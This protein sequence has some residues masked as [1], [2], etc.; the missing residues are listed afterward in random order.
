MSINLTRRSLFARTAAVAVV[1]AAPAAVAKP[2]EQ[3]PIV[4]EAAAAAPSAP[5]PILAAIKEHRRLWRKYSTL[6]MVLSDAVDKVRSAENP[7]PFPLIAWRNY[8]AIGGSELERARDEFLRD[9]VASPKKIEKEYRA[10]KAKERAKLRAEREWYKR[11]GLEDLRAEVENLSKAEERAGNVLGRIRPTTAAGAGALVAYVRQDAE[12]VEALDSWHRAALANA[13]KAL[14]A[15]PAEALPPEG[16]EGQRMDLDVIN[17]TTHM[18]NADAAIDRLHKQYD[19]ADCR[20]D[21][22]QHNVERDTA[23]EVL[24]STR[25]RTWSGIVAK[26]EAVSDRRLI[27]DYARHGEISA[28]LAADVLRYFGASAV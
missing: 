16:F 23:L 6:S 5:D 11:N 25:T 21:Y 18:Q 2:E 19:D 17:A 14:L 22:Y 24:R 12:S 13:A 7:R 8:T 26:A 10:A 28:S 9:K 4:I 15:M 20:D 3:Q 1:A 27:E